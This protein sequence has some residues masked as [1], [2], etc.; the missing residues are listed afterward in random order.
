MIAQRP[1]NNDVT[2][3]RKPYTIQ[4][5]VSLTGELMG[6]TK[7]SKTQM[8]HDVLIM[9]LPGSC[10]PSFF[11]PKHC[12]KVASKNATTEIEAAN[13]KRFRLVVS[14]AKLLCFRLWA[15]ECVLRFHVLHMRLRFDIVPRSRRDTYTHVQKHCTFQGNASITRKACGANKTKMVRGECQASCNYRNVLLGIMHTSVHYLVL[16]HGHPFINNVLFKETPREV[17]ISPNDENQNEDKQK[18]HA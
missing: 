1:A 13:S 7:I 8:M 11:L 6:Q 14:L 10:W 17:I 12:E 2:H 3:I 18:M 4:G 9:M 15:A 5:K 16:R